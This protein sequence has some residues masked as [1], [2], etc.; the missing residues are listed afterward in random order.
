[1]Y[2]RIFKWY[3]CVNNN[4]LINNTEHIC[5]KITIMG[6]FVSGICLKKYTSALFMIKY[7]YISKVIIR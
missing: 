2:I 1:M 3:Q 4:Y 5:N 6:R 7:Q